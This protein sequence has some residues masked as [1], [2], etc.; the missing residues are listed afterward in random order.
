MITKAKLAG[1]LLGLTILFVILH[2]MFY[3][4]LGVEEPMFFILSLLFAFAF[5]IYVC[6]TLTVFGYNAI[7]HQINKKRRVH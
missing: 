5:V 4:I 1:I 7:R 2:N 3:A 6:V